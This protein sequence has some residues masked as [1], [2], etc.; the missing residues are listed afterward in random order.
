[1]PVLDV[2]AQ[3]RPADCRVKN[4]EQAGQETAFDFCVLEKVNSDL[5]ASFS[6]TFKWLFRS[7]RGR[8]FFWQ[9]AH[10]NVPFHSSWTF[11]ALQN[12][13]LERMIL[14]ILGT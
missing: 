11:S 13:P 12:Y 4:F 9:M 3:R 7:L 8:K 10:M 5:F 2:K 1:M 6:M 14:S